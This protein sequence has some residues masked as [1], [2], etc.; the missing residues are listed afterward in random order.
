AYVGTGVEGRVYG[1]DRAGR[2]ALVADTDERQ[3]GALVM[4]GP[5]RLVAAS[6][7]AV[8]HALKGVGGPHPGWTGKGVDAGVRARFGRMTWEASGKL[9]ISTRTGN[10]KEPDDTWSDWSRDVDQPGPVA[11]PPARFFQV[12]ARFAKDPAAELTEFEVAFVTDNLRATID[13]V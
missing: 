6:D 5:T 2:A 10:T 12:R 8:F 7:P 11:S 9:D 3:I 4:S 13:D 1:V